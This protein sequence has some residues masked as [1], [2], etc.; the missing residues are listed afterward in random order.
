MAAALAVGLNLLLIPWLGLLGAALALALGV[1]G[2][3]VLQHAW[4]AHR[5]RTYL[6]LD[7][8]WA[9]LL[10]FAALYGAI[11]VT[12]LLGR[13]WAFRTEVLLSLLL[14][15]LLILLL[16]TMLEKQERQVV[17]AALGARA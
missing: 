7:L 2:M 4:N 10:K 1:L 17:W 5:N 13:N 6:A 15:V 9:R 12:T 14:T 16:Y 8:E 11:A 3:V